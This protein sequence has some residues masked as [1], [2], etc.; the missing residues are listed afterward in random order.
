MDEYGAKPD[1]RSFT[2][3]IDSF[4][5]R[6][7]WDSVKEADN[8]LSKLVDLYLAGELGFEPDVTCW[9][10]VIRGWTRLAKRKRKAAFI[11]EEVM[12]KMIVLEDEGKITVKA[13][14]VVY[15][16]VLMGYVNARCMEDAERIFGIME[17]LWKQGD[18]EMKPEIRSY[19]ALM[20][21][22][23]KC[24]TEGA[25]SN[26]EAM[27]ERLLENYEDCE[28]EVLSGCYRALLFGYTRSNDPLK[29]EE[30]LKLIV[31]KGFELDSILFDKVIEAYT[32]LEDV[33][34][35]KNVYVVFKLMESC[36]KQ[37][38]LE[39]NERV[40]TA[41][42]RA[43]AKESKSGMTEKSQKIIQRMEQLYKDGNDAVAPTIFTYNALLKNCANSIQFGEEERKAAFN[44]AISTFNFLRSS[45]TLAPD[46]VTYNSLIK[47]SYLLKEGPQRDN[48]IIATTKQYVKDGIGHES[49]IRVLEEYASQELFRKLKTAL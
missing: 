32:N 15:L 19:T 6:S 37:G 11:A 7:D 27:L 1:V 2:I 42:I 10:T 3:Y 25:M 23:T 22:W 31:N 9:T 28:D 44:I 30:T 36:R 8:I 18:E 39:A 20:E 41:L 34:K 24:T 5:Q 46:W 4:A 35:I 40:Y 47:C 17:Y 48:L 43:I 12:E 29:A 13:D 21:G 16:S 14:T 45:E 38:K 33:D 26:A 49:F